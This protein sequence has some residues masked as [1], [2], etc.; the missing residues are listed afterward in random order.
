M[1]RRVSQAREIG[2]GRGLGGST[3][4]IARF[5]NIGAVIEVEGM[6]EDE[7]EENLELP[8]EG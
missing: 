8:K 5:K 1:H 6:K 2:E 4:Y 7:K 3:S